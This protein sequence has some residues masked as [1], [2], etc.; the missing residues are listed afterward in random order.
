[1]EKGSNDKKSPNS[2][3]FNNL[4][5]FKM[6][7]SKILVVCIVLTAIFISC[8]DDTIESVDSDL[9]ISEFVSLEASIEE[10]ENVVDEYAMYAGGLDFEALSGKGNGH[11][12][13][14]AKFF[15]ECVTFSVEETDN[16]KTIT[17]SFAEDCVD[18]KGNEVSGTITIVKEVSDS[19]KSRSISFEDFSVNGYVVN[20]TKTYEYNAEN[21]NGNPE[22]GGN[23]DLTIETEEGLITKKG[24]RLV[25]VTAGGDTDTFEDNELTITGSHSLTKADG[26]NFEM[27]ITTALIKPAAC[28]Y[29]AEGIKEIVR[30][31]IESTLDY[32]DGTCDSIAILTTGDTVTEIEI[33]SGKKRKHD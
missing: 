27:E 7:M 17:I 14:R 32:G 23:V 20:G 11:I 6:K 24:S 31:G 1:M 18:K 13:D 16:I 4:N 10:V 15:S 5:N 21:A 29:I 9:S 22:M 26:S 33:K 30:D 25:E 3:M 2:Y 28:K 12:F 19:S 8:E